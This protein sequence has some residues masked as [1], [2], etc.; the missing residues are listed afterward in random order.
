MNIID[1]AHY[2]ILD[3]GSI[4]NIAARIKSLF[5]NSTPFIIVRNNNAHSVDLMLA[6]YEKMNAEIGIVREIDK[7]KYTNELGDR[8]VDVKYDSTIQTE[9]PW[10]SNVSLKL[11]TDNTLS[12]VDNYANITELVC[13][14]PCKYG[15]FTKIISN[16]DV[17]DEI[18]KADE[19]LFYEIYEREIYYS[20]NNSAYNRGKML[21]YDD[22]KKT[23]VFSYNYTQALKSDK[24][25]ERD[26]QIVEK[27]DTYFLGL[28]KMDYIRL[29]KGD[30]LLFNDE[31]VLHGRTEVITDRHYK[32]CSI[33][34]AF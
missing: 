1:I 2:D 12:T 34:L 24:N 3:D 5:L 27:L 32:K 20:A 13:I 8:W 26:L 28:D 31:L 4:E 21:R 14:N 19:Q 17:V 29:E 9:T 15:G 16:N 25:S 6:F 18:K 33:Y 10:K 30:A 11:H 23:F 7:N 22:E